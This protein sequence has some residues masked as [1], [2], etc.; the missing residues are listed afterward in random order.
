MPAEDLWE[1][2]WGPPPTDERDASDEWSASQPRARHARH[3]KSG[4]LR[5]IGAARHRRG[6]LLGLGIA[7]GAVAAAIGV[8]AWLSGTSP[9][10]STMLHPTSANLE[11][12]QSQGPT[13]QI[14]GVDDLCL[15]DSKGGVANGNPVILATCTGTE[16]QPGRRPEVRGGAVS[17]AAR[18]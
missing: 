8:G 18:W 3:R 14:V 13:G 12:I 16:Q 7:L 15:T 2:Q 5:H 9:T 1:T 10:M 11:S 4:P 6:Q 17:S